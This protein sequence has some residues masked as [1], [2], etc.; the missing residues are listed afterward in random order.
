MSLI[1]MGAGRD[2]LRRRNEHVCIV[3]QS[4]YQKWKV[5]HAELDFFVV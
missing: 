3:E 1:S 2:C 5:E 4:R